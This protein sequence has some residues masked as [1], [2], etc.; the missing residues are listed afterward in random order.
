MVEG[1]Q[2][3]PVI[4]SSRSRYEGAIDAMK[5]WLV[6]HGF[7]RRNLNQIEFSVEKPAAHLT[8]DDRAMR[9][10]GEFP[11]IGKMLTFKPWNKGGEPAE[12]EA[13]KTLTRALRHDSDFYLTYQSNIAVAIQDVFDGHVSPEDI[14]RLSNEAAKRFM[15][16]WGCGRGDTE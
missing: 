1:L 7:L 6:S 3:Q 14:D 10:T 13:V 2:V 11:S 9:F 12:E 4:Y 5:E 15:G 8:L 16:W